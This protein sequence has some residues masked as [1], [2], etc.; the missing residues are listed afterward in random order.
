MHGASRGVSGRARPASAAQN[1]LVRGQNCRSE[2][3]T[4]L[5]EE[6]VAFRASRHPLIRPLTKGSFVPSEPCLIEGERSEPVLTITERSCS[7]PPDPLREPASR[8][9]GGP[10]P[11]LRE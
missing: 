5:I 11:G 3:E 7:G 8:V 10:R 2:Y 9:S 6:S 1:S 4:G